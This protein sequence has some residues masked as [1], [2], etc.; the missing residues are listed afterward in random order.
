[1]QCFKQGTAMGLENGTQQQIRVFQLAGNCKGAFWTSVLCWMYVENQLG[2]KRALGESW[3]KA[4][5]NWCFYCLYS[6]NMNNTK[7][8]FRKR[9][10]IFVLNDYKCKV[11]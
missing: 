2:S 6:D 4:S 10:L 7:E 5:K 11:N 3:S 9:K 1:M 8:A